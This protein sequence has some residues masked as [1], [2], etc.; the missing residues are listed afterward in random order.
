[1]GL[2]HQGP[3]HSLIY[4]VD[5]LAI[6]EDEFTNTG[7]SY[8]DHTIAYLENEINVLDQ[9]EKGSLNIDRVDKDLAKLIRN[10]EGENLYKSEIGFIRNN[11]SNVIDN[12]ENLKS[13]P[14]DIYS[15]RETFEGFYKFLKGARDVA[16]AK[17]QKE[18]ENY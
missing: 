16:S 8:I 4:V 10:K 13:S 2:Y 3:A 18:A 15:S 9:V 14:K 7:K 12:L 5:R 11:Y 17:F 1:M 6:R